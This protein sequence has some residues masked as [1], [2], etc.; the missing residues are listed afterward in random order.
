MKYS[1]THNGNLIGTGNLQTRRRRYSLHDVSTLETIV[2]ENGS[3]L[4][5]RDYTS[6]EA[7]DSA[8]WY[9]EGTHMI[10][11]PLQVQETQD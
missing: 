6:P 2:D 4:A 11:G 8:P 9:H 3:T 10:A 5:A 1:V 7:R